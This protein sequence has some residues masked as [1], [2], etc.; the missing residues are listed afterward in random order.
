MHSGSLAS[1]RRPGSVIFIR[2]YP[3]LN[4][5]VQSVS[6][7]THPHQRTIYRLDTSSGSS[8]MMEMDNLSMIPYIVL[9]LRFTSIPSN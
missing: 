9:H 5:I 6:I 3:N 4:S 7:Q 1:S 8:F 2:A